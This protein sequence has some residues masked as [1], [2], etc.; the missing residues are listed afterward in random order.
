MSSPRAGQDV[1]GGEEPDP[2]VPEDQQYDDREPQERRDDVLAQEDRSRARE[3]RQHV[4]EQVVERLDGREDDQD[5]EDPDRDRIADHRVADQTLEPDYEQDQD[6]P[7]RHH[8]PGDHDERA[9]HP[10]VV[11]LL[12]VDRE[13][14]RDAPIQPHRHQHLAERDE[15]QRIGERAVVGLR[16]VPGDQHLDEEVD[17]Q[18]DESARQQQ[19]RPPDL[20]VRRRG[21]WRRDGLAF[22]RGHLVADAGAPCVV[23]AERPAARYRDRPLHVVT[24]APRASQGA[25]RRGR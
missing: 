8:G 21:A 11:V 22:G 23:R 20:A 16:E 15:R 5:H 24:E 4:A 1:P 10:V 6:Q 3:H 13:E 25:T 19:A 14:A 9:E 12:V 7:E 17:P 2:V 18:G